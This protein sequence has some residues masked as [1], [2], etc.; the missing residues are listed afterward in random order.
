MGDSILE[1]LS[2]EVREALFKVVEDILKTE[3]YQIQTEAGSKKGRRISNA[4][5]F[6]W[7]FE[8]ENSSVKYSRR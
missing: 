1:D 7:T 4:A 8:N 3:N 2:D 5:K 6:Y